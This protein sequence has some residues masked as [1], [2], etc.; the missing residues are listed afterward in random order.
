MSRKAVISCAIALVWLLTACNLLSTTPSAVI[1]TSTSQPTVVIPTSTPP[2]A[3]DT[4]VPTSAPTLTP[5]VPTATASS[6][7]PATPVPVSSSASTNYVDDRSTPAQVIV[8]FYNAINR[9]EYSRAYGYY[10]NPSTALGA[11][12]AFTNGY[13]NTISVALSFGQIFAEGAAG[14]LYFTVPVLLNANEANNI[15]STYA[16]CYVVR[17]VQPGNFGAPPFHPMSI[18]SGSGKKVSAGTDPNSACTGQ[19][20]G[21]STIPAAGESLNIDKNN[22]IDNRSGAIETISSLLNAINLKQYVRAY[23]YFEDPANFPGDFNAYAAGY[24]DTEALA[25]TFGTVQTEGAAGSMYF[26]VP[27]VLKATLTSNAIQT[28]VGCYT[29]RLAQPANQIEPPYHPMAIR[30][31]KFTQVDNNADTSSLLATACQ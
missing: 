7:P 26:N 1:P 3:T 29:L 4:S 31:G 24:A 22:F 15:Q 10:S 25:A 13:T 23:S 9:H 21:P 18:D 28:F 20:V 11:F 27:L 17:Q 19:Q 6:A 8:S 30:D 2:S 16:V 12:D 5:T 14:S